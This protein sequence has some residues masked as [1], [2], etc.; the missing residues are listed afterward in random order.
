MLSSQRAAMLYV[1][2]IVR[3]TGVGKAYSGLTVYAI[4]GAPAHILIEAHVYVRNSSRFSRR[5]TFFL[6]RA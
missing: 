5:T 3:Y 2:L 4:V 6:L 1:K